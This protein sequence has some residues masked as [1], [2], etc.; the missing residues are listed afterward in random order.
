MKQCWTLLLGLSLIAAGCGGGSDSPGGVVVPEPDPVTLQDV[1]AA[2]FTPSCAVTGCHVA[3][4]AAFGL[5]LGAGKALNN[6]VGVASAERPT[7]DRVKRFDPDNSY[8]YMKVTAD[9]RILGDPMPPLPPPLAD[10]QIAIL[11]A[12]IEQGANP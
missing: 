6:L 9:P 11:R 8:V 12:W 7:F 3:G 5:E 10:P 1:Q 4:T 2:L